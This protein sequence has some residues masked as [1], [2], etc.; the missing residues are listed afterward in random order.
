MTTLSVRV[1]HYRYAASKIAEN[2][3]GSL[4]LRLPRKLAYWAAIRV[5]VHATT[6]RY[7]SQVVPELTVLDALKRWGNE[8]AA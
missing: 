7:S 4:S 5:V 8:E 1:D 2:F 3:W 6:G